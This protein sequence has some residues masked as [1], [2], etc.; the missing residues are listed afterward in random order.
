MN[1]LLIIYGIKETPSNNRKSNSNSNSNHINKHPNPSR[2]KSVIHNRILTVTML[3]FIIILVVNACLAG[4]VNQCL[5]KLQIV[6]D[7]FRR[8]ATQ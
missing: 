8:E 3:V 4:K 7:I 6:L 5:V 1:K 2:N